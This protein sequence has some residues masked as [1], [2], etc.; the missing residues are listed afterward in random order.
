MGIA[1]IALSL[2]CWL[3]KLER[4]FF[5]G[6]VLCELNANLEKPRWKV[7]VALCGRMFL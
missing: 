1:G 7:A 6:Q 3:Q 5:V 4:F 2:V